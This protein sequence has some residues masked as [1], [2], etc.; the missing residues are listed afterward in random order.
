M[1]LYQVPD[2]FLVVVT[3]SLAVQVGPLTSLSVFAFRAAAAEV[4]ATHLGPMLAA[5]EFLLIPSLGLCAHQ[6]L[7]PSEVVLQS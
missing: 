1:E 6:D 7:W 5:A 2:P 4:V 3:Y